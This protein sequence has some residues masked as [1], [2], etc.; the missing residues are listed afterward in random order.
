MANGID[1]FRWHH[2]SVNDPK[3]GLVARKAG[4]RLGDVL[5]VWALVLEQASASTERGQFSEIDGEATDF[6]LGAEDGTTARILE[7]MQ[8][9][10]LLTGD[11]VTRWEERQPKRER[12][13]STAAERKRA[14]RERDAASDGDMTAVTPSHAKSHQVTPR[15]EKRREELTPLTTPD[16]VVVASKTGNLPGIQAK[17]EC[18]HQEIIALYHEVLPQ[19]PRIRDWTTARQQHLRARWNEDKSRQS[20][21]Y[22]RRFF[23]YV[24]SCD[25]LVGKGG[26]NGRKPFFADLEWLVQ[27]KNFTKVREQK[28]EQ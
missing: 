12:V 17:P 24:G 21:A 3:F 20:L 4:A 5:A 8:S 22:W 18:P 25:F 26:N 11:R 2:G 15:E 27:Q 19:C 7:A 13:D 23:E 10:S 14:Q 9:R 1:W 28:Y 6:L 16:G